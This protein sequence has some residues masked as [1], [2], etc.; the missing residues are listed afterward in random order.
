MSRS[1][2]E[3]PSPHSGDLP[4]GAYWSAHPP[5]GYEHDDSADYTVEGETIRFMWDYG[6]TVP[7]WVIGSGLVP[8]DKEWL[9]RALG[10]RYPLVRDL[11]AWGAAMDH[12]DANPPL[13]TGEAYAE[14]DRQ[15][16]ALVERVQAEVGERFTVTYHPW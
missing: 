16:R 8:D 6:V 4:D 3:P 5:P 1:D 7:L 12:L 11:R 9:R 15:A 2:R 14:L 10:L 13:R